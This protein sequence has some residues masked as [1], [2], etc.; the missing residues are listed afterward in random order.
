MMALLPDDQLD[1]VLARPLDK[2]MPNTIVDVDRLREQVNEVRERGYAVN[3][4]ENRAHVCAVAAA[5]ADPSGRPVAAVAISMPDLRFDQ[6][7][8]AEWG[9]WVVGTARAITDALAD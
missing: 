3:I 9:S 6:S 4:A 7:R 8:V 5:V 1:A 2:V